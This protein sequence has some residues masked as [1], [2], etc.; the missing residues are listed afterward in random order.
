M[1]RILRTA[2]GLIISATL[3]TGATAQ[4]LPFS[5]GG[6][7][8]LARGPDR[9]TLGFG[10]PFPDD[11]RTV[12]SFGNPEDI[13]IGNGLGL[14][15]A[16]TWLSTGGGTSSA[17][18]SAPVLTYSFGVEHENNGV[19]AFRQ[20]SGAVFPTSGSS[21][22]TGVF[23]GFGFETPIGGGYS[24][25]SIAVPTFGAALNLGYG[26]AD[27][28]GFGGGF[29]ADGSGIYGRADA[30]M[31]IPL[32]GGMMLS[33]GISYRLFDYGEI[34]DDGFQAFLRLTIPL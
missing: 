29:Q 26:W 21:T 14:L 32:A 12:Q 9:V 7:S 31:A 2:A 6:P 25:S 22:F 34:E 3:A 30:Y 5:F 17:Y 1:K 23:V 16:L 27:V 13:I 24:S 28:D 20:A 19:E 15:L 4:S 18:S 33:P 8:S 11:S 10:I